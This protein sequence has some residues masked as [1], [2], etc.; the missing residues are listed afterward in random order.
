MVLLLASRE[1]LTW[2]VSVITTVSQTTHALG[3]MQVSHHSATGAVMGHPMAASALGLSEG[4]SRP[5]P[6]TG[7]PWAAPWHLLRWPPQEQSAAIL[8]FLGCGTYV[9][10]T[11]QAGYLD[12]TANGLRLVICSRMH[13]TVRQRM[14]HS[15]HLSGTHRPVVQYASLVVA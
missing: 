12:G 2:C 9:V 1:T 11:S 10:R 8:S 15:H 14:V 6:G 3:W 7:Y 5:L 13:I 4:D